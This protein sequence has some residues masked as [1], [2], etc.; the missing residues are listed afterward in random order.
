MK[1][2]KTFE[3]LLKEP[4]IQLIIEKLQQDEDGVPQTWAG[5]QLINGFKKND[6]FVKL[7]EEYKKYKK[8]NK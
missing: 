5:Q 2:K 8:L 3:E 4:Y 1:K 6:E 7:Y